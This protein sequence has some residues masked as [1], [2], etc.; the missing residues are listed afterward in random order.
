MLHSLAVVVPISVFYVKKKSNRFH[1]LKSEVR[2][3]LTGDF[4]LLLKSDF[5]NISTLLFMTRYNVHY[6]A[7]HVY[8]FWFTHPK[9][10]FL[11]IL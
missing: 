8:L 4:Q 2:C 7:R 10:H 1:R 3:H 6:E 5:V 11:G 9:V